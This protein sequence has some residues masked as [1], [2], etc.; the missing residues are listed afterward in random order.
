MISGKYGVME[1]LSFL[2]GG[3]FD[4][5]NSYAKGIEALTRYKQIVE[6]EK[7]RLEAVREEGDNSIL[8]ELGQLIFLSRAIDTAKNALS[9]AKEQS[10]EA[11]HE[12]TQAVH[13]VVKNS[14][15]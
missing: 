15:Y 10:A 1:Y 13:G 3:G 4:N 8:N 9:V 2:N 6:K 12:L 5:I 7:A 14:K 11:Y